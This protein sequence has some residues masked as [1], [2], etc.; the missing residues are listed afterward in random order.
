MGLLARL[1]WR[2]IMGKM[3]MLE[4]RRKKT[5]PWWDEEY[6][7]NENVSMRVSILAVE[8]GDHLPYQCTPVH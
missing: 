5:R 2:W 7:I 3:R 8:Q 4:K 6:G 1:K